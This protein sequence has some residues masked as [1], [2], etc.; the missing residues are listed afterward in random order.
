MKALVTGG[1]GF[2]GSHLVDALVAAGDEV[3]VLD[4]LRRGA[5]ANIDRHLCS[6]HVTFIEGD[7]WDR[8]VVLEASAG[9]DIVYHLAAQSNVIGAI[10]DTDYSFTTNVAGTYNVL[11]AAAN[12]GVRRLVFASSREVYGEPKS[13]PVPESAPLDAKNVYGA[14]KIAG[15]AYCRVWQ[16]TTG[17]ECQILRFAN[18]YGPRDRDRVIPTW[19]QRASRGEPL[20]LYGG[21]QLIDFVWVGTAVKALLAA[22]GSQ[23]SDPINVGSGTGVTLT[24]LAHRILEETGSASKLK[25]LPAR[26]VEVVRFVADVR[27]MQ[28]VLGV[29]PEPDPLARLSDCLAIYPRVAPSA[30]RLHNSPAWRSD[31]AAAGCGGASRLASQ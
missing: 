2:L 18:V 12:A 31:R 26:R 11:K 17:L 8:A 14:S 28:R 25:I 23:L 22:A 3:I 5:L 21:E 24:H 6:K 4:N 9:V 13:I 30:L 27:Q 7:I 20:E 16:S 29:A 10:Q 19:L 15:E 1:A